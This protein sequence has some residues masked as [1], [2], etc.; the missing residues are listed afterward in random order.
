MKTKTGEK[1]FELPSAK[2]KKVYLSLLAINK[3]N[4]LIQARIYE[5]LKD[6]DLGELNEYYLFLKQDFSKHQ[7]VEEEKLNATIESGKLNDYLSVFPKVSKDGAYLKLFDN[8]IL[9]KKTNKVRK[10]KDT[11]YLSVDGKYVYINGKKADISEGV[12]KIQT[13]DNY[14]KGN[15][16]Y[17]AQFKLDFENISEEMDFKASG[18]SIADISYFNENFVVLSLTYNG[19]IVGT[20]GSV[21]VLI[22]LQRSKKQP[23]AYLVDLNIL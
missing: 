4:M 10:I 18:I 13:V 16:K 14:L 23:T 15:D 1:K 17:E 12:Q 22:D 5:K 9:E 3:E 20:A 6:G 21:N 7:I 19:I 8:Y 11:D 2:G